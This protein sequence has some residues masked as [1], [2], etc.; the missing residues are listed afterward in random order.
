MKHFD[1]ATIPAQM[2]HLDRDKRGLPIPFIVLRDNDNK[3]HFT[4]ND[5][6]PLFIEKEGV[7]PETHPHWPKR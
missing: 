3:P 5:T 4:I 6:H 1:P 2:Q 7:A